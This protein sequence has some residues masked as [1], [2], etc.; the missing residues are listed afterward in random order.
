MAGGKRV[1]AISV[2]SVRRAV[3]GSSIGIAALWMSVFLRAAAP[4]GQVP[5]RASAPAADEA[6]QHAAVI[7]Q[8]RAGCHNGR[9]STSATA[10]GVV[11]DTIDLR[12]RR[13]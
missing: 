5:A 11:F 7:K 9:V 1:T 4:A 13:R 6:T 2:R 8:D 10:S 3:L 12:Q